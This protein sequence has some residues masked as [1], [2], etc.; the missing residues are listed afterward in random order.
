[1]KLTKTQLNN[2]N[3]L[4]GDREL[5]GSQLLERYIWL[6]TVRPKYKIGD[7][8][9]FSSSIGVTHFG[10]LVDNFK[11][12]ITNIRFDS[13]GKTV[14]YTI[15]YDYSLNNKKYHSEAYERTSNIKGKTRAQKIVN[16]LKTQK[17]DC[18]ESIPIRF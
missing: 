9:I 6:N 10:N 17:D 2:L 4:K 3:K 7:K 13:I 18:C 16:V 5:K 12:V 11:G 14:V 15:E 8:I 1:M